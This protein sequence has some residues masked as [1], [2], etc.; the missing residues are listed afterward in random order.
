MG[1]VWGEVRSW[2]HECVEQR[3]VGREEASWRKNNRERGDEVFI[4]RYC[5][6][7]CSELWCI[8]LVVG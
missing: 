6:C 3:G 1:G 8:D 2:R 7:N 5:Y 4:V